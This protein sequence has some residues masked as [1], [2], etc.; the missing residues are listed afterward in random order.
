MGTTTAHLNAVDLFLIIVIVTTVYMS[1]RKGIIFEGFMLLGVVCV[2][3]VSVHYY[4]RFANVLRIQ[5]FGK[6]AATAFPAFG[7]LSLLIFVVFLMIS[8]GW[9]LILKINFHKKIDRYGGIILSLVRSYFGCGLIFFALL[10]VNQEHASSR[11]RQSVSYPIFRHVAVDFYRATYSV[12][13]ARFFPKEPFNEKALDLI[14][15]AKNKNTK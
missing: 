3:F 5:F 12:L 13:I 6:Q 1:A 2:N 4:V 8:K 7:L 11:A 9:N 10:L 14:T 15:E